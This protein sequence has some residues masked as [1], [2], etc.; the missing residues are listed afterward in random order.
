[1]RNDLENNNYIYIFDVD[2]EFNDKNNKCFLNK[3]TERTNDNID[4]NDT[5]YITEDNEIEKKETL[6]K[7]ELNNTLYIGCEDGTIKMIE[8]SKESFVKKFFK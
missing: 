6:E 5:N 1:M 2:V 8:I 7:K 4:K 3:K